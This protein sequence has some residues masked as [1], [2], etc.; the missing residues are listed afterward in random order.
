VELS[1]LYGDHSVDLGE[2]VAPTRLKVAVLYFLAA[3]KFS[4]QFALI[5]RNCIGI[6]A[7]QSFDVNPTE[8]LSHLVTTLS[9]SS[10]TPNADDARRKAMEDVPPASDSA[11]A[12]GGKAAPPV[13]G[14]KA[15]AVQPAVTM[16]LKPN[17]R[18]ALFL[19][20]SLLREQDPLWLGSE[21]GILCA[22]L[23]ALLR[24][25]Y[26]VYVHQCSV[27]QVPDPSGPI[28]VPQG[29]VS[30]LW[31]PMK[32][33]LD[34]PLVLEKQPNS[35]DY[36]SAGRLS[37]VSVFFLLG[38]ATPSTAAPSSANSK[39]PILLKLVLPRI[40]VVHVEKQLRSVRDR[41]MDAEAKAN[42]VALQSARHDFGTTVCVLMGLL[43]NGIIIDRRGEGKGTSVESDNSNLFEI[44]ESKGSGTATAYT[45]TVP[46]SL[47]D[48]R[49]AVR[50][51]VS[52]NPQVLLN[53]A[54]MC[55]PERDVYLLK[56]GEVCRFLR[57]TLGYK[58]LP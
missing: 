40:D 19:L 32:A 27:E 46:V 8:E 56:D 26:P 41:L 1:E 9:S 45:L 57:A 58:V 11:T 42:P 34:F 7:D 36:S 28:D 53:L 54:N 49:T 51:S 18:D 2:E 31:S 13:K 12:K 24:A 44:V 50:V 14:G 22:D 3:I 33:P 20:S 16:E 38:D 35:F 48:N 29:S 43:Q 10:A 39:E 52:V 37:H 23:H 30:T 4:N 55:C 17:G 5:T 6:S 21:E 15:A 47:P 25:T